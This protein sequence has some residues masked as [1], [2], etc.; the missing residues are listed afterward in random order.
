MS[1]MNES[2]TPLE[3]MHQIVSENNIMIW[4][5]FLPMISKKEINQEMDGKT[6]LMKC[7]ET[8]SPILQKKIKRLIHYG[9]NLNTCIHGK[10]ALSY[11]VKTNEVEVAKWM[12]Q[13]GADPTKGNI[14]AEMFEP[15]DFFDINVEELRERLIELG[16]DTQ[17]VPYELSVQPLENI[18]MLKYILSL[19]LPEDEYGRCPF[20]LACQEGHIEKIICLL[21][22]GLYPTEI[23][24][25]PS[26]LKYQ[27]AEEELDRRRKKEK[28]HWFMLL[29]SDKK[30]SED[31]IISGLTEMHNQTVT[32]MLLPFLAR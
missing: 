9:A 31:S 5:M 12:I 23:M 7:C 32:Q 8:S 20:T 21:E 24:D 6:L 15:N 14:L 25:Y 10:N 18:D 29:M 11:L 19:N 28:K 1:T 16:A 13:M 17:F 22:H 4:D 30:A 2:G 27:E 3:L 26:D